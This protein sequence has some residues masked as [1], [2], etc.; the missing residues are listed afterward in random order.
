M[1][2]HRKVTTTSQVVLELLVGRVFCFY[3]MFVLLFW[4]HSPA[5]SSGVSR[6]QMQNLVLTMLDVHF[7]PHSFPATE[8]TIS[9]T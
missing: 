9:C 8:A 3:Y 2:G 1:K 7:K 4:F 5:C 6:Y